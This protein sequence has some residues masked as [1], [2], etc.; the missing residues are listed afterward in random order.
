M[1]VSQVKQLDLY[2][3]DKAKWGELANL[4]SEAESQCDY[5]Y[6]KNEKSRYALLIELQY[7]LRDEDRDLIRYLL[8]QEIIAR[9][10]FSIGGG[11][12]GLLLSAYLLATFKNPNDILLYY[13]AKNSN[14]D[15]SC[16]IDTEFLFYALRDKTK[17]YVQQNFPEIYD[18][19]GGYES[20]IDYESSVMDWWERLSHNYP[21]KEEDESLYTLYRRNI[22]FNNYDIATEHLEKWKASTPDSADKNS[23][24]KHM[25]IELEDYA[26]VIELLKQELKISDSHWDRTSCYR[27][28]LE[29]YTKTQQS[30]NGLKIVELIDDELKQFSDWKN[31]GLGRMTIEQI[32]EFSLLTDNPEI[33]VEA[34]E[35]AYKWLM[36]AK[37]NISYVGLECAMKAAEKSTCHTEFNQ[38]EKM[39]SVERKRIDS[40][41]KSGSWLKSFLE[42][43]FR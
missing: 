42:R 27:D 39:L 23:T 14:F 12:D 30:I 11:G 7:D 9:R 17:A 13:Q 26:A 33:T 21:D 16:T 2:R 34:F 8:Q 43:F 3:D 37:N 5:I 31:I 29:Y 1:R 10:N 6:D 28:L 15:A 41:F 20:K 36:K 25:Y 38:L 35:I 22:Y 24:L 40:D 4:P 18:D 19:L 32:F